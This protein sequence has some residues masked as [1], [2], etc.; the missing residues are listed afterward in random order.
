MVATSSRDHG[1]VVGRDA[2]GA[3]GDDRRRLPPLRVRCRGGRVAK[4]TFDAADRLSGYRL[5]ELF[6]GLQATQTSFPVQY[7]G[8]NVPQAWAAG[9]VIRLIAILAGIH[10]TTDV[11]GSRLYVNPVLPDWLPAVTIHNLRAGG[12]SLDL[13]LRDG[14]VEVPTNTT[15]FE[16]I[17]GH[18]P[19]PKAP[20][21]SA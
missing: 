18:A 20:E 8:A 5:P 12:G 16:V 17:H 9:S 15:K 10:A 7:P 19:R 1:V 13:V 6:A 21:I 11:T 4:G 3:V 2:P 14:E